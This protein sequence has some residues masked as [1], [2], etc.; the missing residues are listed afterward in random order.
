MIIE[1]LVSTTNEN[2]TVN[3]APMGP[4]I[5]ET[6][7]RFELRPFLT[8][9]TYANLKRTGEGIVHITDNVELLARAAVNQLD[10]LPELQAGRAVS[11]MAV[12]RSCRWY[13]FRV[14]SIT[15]HPPRTMMQCRTVYEHR[16]RDFVGFNRAKNCVLEA[17]IL[18]TRVSFLPVEEIAEQFRRFQTVIQKT[19]GVEEHIAFEM[20]QHYVTKALS[21][22]DITSPTSVEYE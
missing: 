15:E 10:E 1:T 9:Q 18:A 16:N 17:S 11:V 22:M 5:G 12:S 4:S 3:L 7:E 20:L 6:W 21:K 19:G 13:E 8:S 2:G 14:D